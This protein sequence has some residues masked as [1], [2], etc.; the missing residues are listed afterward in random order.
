[1]ILTMKIYYQE[2]P[3]W[4]E[5]KGAKMDKKFKTIEN[6]NTKEFDILL[7]F[8]SGDTKKKY[9]F[10]TDELRKEIYISYYKVEDDLYVLTPI[11]NQDEID[12]CRNILEDIKNYK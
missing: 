12:M 9:I 7:E 5:S 1:M 4:K 2:M 10:Y 3:A 11:K 8:T 6:G